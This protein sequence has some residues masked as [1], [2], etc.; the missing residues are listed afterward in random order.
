MTFPRRGAHAVLLA[1]VL[2]VA[3]TA[4]SSAAEFDGEVAEIR[5]QTSQIRGLE[6]LAEVPL[7]VI[8]PSVL[9]G[10]LTAASQDERSVYRSVI[11]Q[12][13]MAVLGL[14]TPD[15]DLLGAL[16]DLRTEHAAGLYSARERR[17][18]LVSSATMLGPL[19]KLTVSHELTHALQDQH[20]DLQN[21][22]RQQDAN[23]DRLIG[24]RSLVEGDARLTQLLW[25]RQFLTPDEKASLT[26]RDGTQG[27]SQLDQVPLVLRDELLFPYREGY[28]FVATLH[29]DG[30][31]DAVNQAFRD[32]PQ[33]SEQIIHPEKYPAEAPV[34]AP[35]PALAEALGGSWRTLRT[36]VLGE[37]DL[38]ILIE[39][40]SD[41]PTAETAAA[42]WGGDSVALL[43]D[44]AGRLVVVLNTV[45]DSDAEA[46]EF[47]NAFVPTVAARFGGDQ[48]PTLEQPSLARWSTPIGP[49]QILKTAERV[50]VTFAPDEE[51]LEA[52]AAQ[53]RSPQPAPDGP[54]APP[55][56][57]D[58]SQ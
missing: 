51:T 43:E 18:Y 9:R 42:G 36:D 12:K 58:P 54:A 10:R 4:A 28:Q 35:M 32:P 47:Y 15:F 31:Y 38:R 56:D 45:W 14:V 6:P 8:D 16:R 37:L 22:G 52:T 53:F 46:A 23:G 1:G 49:I 33:S 20:F 27:Q 7:E 24:I 3:M 11:S 40:F 21:L 2:A 41:R 39:H 57:V 5:R 19:H 34:S 44:D 29:R 50:L 30:G 25:G 55:T 13:L 26:N 17:M 48:S